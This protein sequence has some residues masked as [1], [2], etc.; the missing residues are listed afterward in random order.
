MIITCEKCNTSFSLDDSLVKETGS[1]VRCSICKHIFIAYPEVNEPENELLEQVKPANQESAGEEEMSLQEEAG[2]DFQTE[3]APLAEG[4]D[5][6]QSKEEPQ[7]AA[8]DELEDIS[9]MFETEEAQEDEQD[10]EL[11]PPLEEEMEL[12]LDLDGDEDLDLETQD[13][14][15]HDEIDMEKDFGEDTKAPVGEQAEEGEG[16][17]EL[18]LD[19][20]LEGEPDT[21]ETAADEN[22]EEDIDFSLME[23]DLEAEK[24]EELE[25]LDIELDVGPKEDEPSDHI[26]EE[27]TE[28]EQEAEAETLELA[29]MEEPTG[30]D[31]KAESAQEGESEEEEIDLSEMTEVQE[32]EHETQ[33]VRAEE[34]DEETE[35]VESLDLELQAEDEQETEQTEESEEAEV[36]LSDLEKLIEQEEYTTED[37][38]RQEGDAAVLEA[39]EAVSDKKEDELTDLLPEELT[40]DV[41]EQETGEAV[42]VSE[43]EQEQAA[44]EYDEETQEEAAQPSEKQPGVERKRRIGAP[45]VILLLLVLL[46][47]GL[48]GAYTMGIQ[49]PFAENLSSLGSKIP[50]VRDFIAPPVTDPGNLKISAIDIVGKFVNNVRSGKLFVI[51]GNAK[52]GYSEP[53]GLIKI[54]G[55]LYSKG[56][57]LEKTETVFCGNVLSDTELVSL[58]MDSIRK[59]LSNRV[60]DKKSNLNIAPG[61]AV[62]FML[63]FSDLPDNL[64]EYTIE[65]VES[66]PAVKK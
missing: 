29:D 31:G 56:K 13:V 12:D 4:F 32:P 66:F 23:Q 37:A 18:E 52:N 39:E 42:A 15:K 61:R 30:Q 21:Q 60:G 20:D 38:G 45:V 54:T 16:F 6:D 17:E 14:E 46:G 33:E 7:E 41:E 3:A 25:E 10:E 43:A 55:K 1:K 5:A 34:T 11:P 36:D 62:P 59:R 35:D 64:E 51:T 24:E 19:F 65:V 9:M 44:E 28:K 49:I 27:P 2:K 57:K 40:E 63:V 47:G 22:A 48:Y 50:F 53:R 26:D 8:S 58:D